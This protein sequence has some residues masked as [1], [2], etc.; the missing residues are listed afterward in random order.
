MARFSR[1]RPKRLTGSQTT[2]TRTLSTPARATRPGTATFAE[3]SGDERTT[4]RRQ[5]RRWTLRPRVRERHP[6]PRHRRGH[7]AG[8]RKSP[9]ALDKAENQHRSLP[10]RHQHY[11]RSCNLASLCSC[12]NPRPAHCCL[13]GAPS[14][15]SVRHSRTVASG[16][17][18][19]SPL[20]TLHFSERFKGKDGRITTVM[21][22]MQVSVRL[23]A[24]SARAQRSRQQR[25]VVAQA[26]ATDGGS[27]PF[28]PPP[29]RKRPL[30]R[31]LNMTLDP[32]IVQ[33][34]PATRP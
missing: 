27:C 23:P 16:R 10:T 1:P 34:R 21:M 11:R 14:A 24:P 4:L 33:V 3:S 7:A 18:L 25:L 26:T 28:M 9:A 15:S 29:H 8:C 5:R 6:H 19:S 30:S 20:A 17:R 22:R 31:E 32:S 12:G 13:S 2:L